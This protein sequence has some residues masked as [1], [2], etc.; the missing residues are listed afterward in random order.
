MQIHEMIFLVILF[1]G[2]FSSS[3]LVCSMVGGLTKNLTSGLKAPEASMAFL[4]VFG[5]LVIF[6]VIG[7]GARKNVEGFCNCPGHEVLKKDKLE[8]TISWQAK[9]NVI[10]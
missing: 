3:C 9:D 1:I 6:I 5:L 4:L 7:S 8:R 10:Y 2:Y